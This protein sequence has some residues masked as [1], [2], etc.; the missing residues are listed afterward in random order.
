MI[1]LLAK[2]R[3]IL[4]GRIHNVRISTSCSFNRRKLFEGLNFQ[5]KKEYPT[6][7]IDTKVC[8]NVSAEYGCSFLGCNFNT[9]SNGNISIGRFNSLSGVSIYCGDASVNFGSFNSI[10]DTKFLLTG[11]DYSRFTTYYIKR[12]VLHDSSNNEVSTKGNINIG[13]DVWIGANS[14]ILSGITIGDGAVIAAGSVVTKDVDAYA[15]WGG[16]PA[17]LIKYR[18]PEDIRLAL[19]KSQWWNASDTQLQKYASY[20]DN[21]VE[22]LINSNFTDDF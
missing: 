13:N 21:G 4:E 19:Q 12:H 18:F 14:I 2:V 22:A 17:K 10:I 3:C 8:G 6:S 9:S 7:L 20:V 15:I 16:N 5:G 1:S 11:H